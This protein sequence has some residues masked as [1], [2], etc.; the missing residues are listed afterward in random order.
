VSYVAPYYRTKH[1]HAL[2]LA[3][4]MRDGGRCVVPG[5]GR[6]A[7]VVDH[8]V[9]RPATATS[10]PCE[11]DRL[12]NLRC[13]CA[14]HDSQVKEKRRGSAERRGGAF[15]VTGCDAQGRSLDPNHPWKQR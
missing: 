6:P 2:R 5:C 11:Q 4:L 8:I 13:L 3:A 12:D 9:A 7:K 14:G 15:R 1:W 10:L